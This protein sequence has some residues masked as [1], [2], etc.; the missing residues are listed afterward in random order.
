M[1]ELNV[2]L[3]KTSATGQRRP[4]GVARL[5]WILADFSVSTESLTNEWPPRLQAKELK[6]CLGNYSGK[7]LG[8]ILEAGCSLMLDLDPG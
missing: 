4:G 5:L 6:P 1:P 3:A 8:L 2:G 7:R